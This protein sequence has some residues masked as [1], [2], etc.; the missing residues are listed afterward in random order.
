MWLLLLILY[1]Q[2]EKGYEGC[3]TGTGTRQ[4]SNVLM[5]TRTAMLACLILGTTTKRCK[6][7]KK[8]KTLNYTRDTEKKFLRYVAL[9]ASSQQRGKTK[10]TLTLKALVLAVPTR[11]GYRLS[12][13]RT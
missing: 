11:L 4:P 2:K 10:S 5:C 12:V 6:K 13:L 7:E 3:A 8:K 1:Y 9:S